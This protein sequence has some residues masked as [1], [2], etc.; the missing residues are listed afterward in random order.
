[1]KASEEVL[2]PE[3]DYQDAVACRYAE[4]EYDSGQAGIDFVEM[5]AWSLLQTEAAHFGKEAGHS[6]I[7]AK[8]HSE[9]VGDRSEIEEARSETEALHPG[10][11]DHFENG[12]DRSGTET[13][14]PARQ[15]V[16][17]AE[18]AQMLGCSEIEEVQAD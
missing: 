12:V 6:G 1:M 8:G 5:G 16:E 2:V 14:I 11:V 13:E 7:E 10:M 18:V 15:V 4:V 9:I 3:E 17:I